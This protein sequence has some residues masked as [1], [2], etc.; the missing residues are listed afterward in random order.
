MPTWPSQN[1]HAVTDTLPVGDYNNLAYSLNLLTNAQGGFPASMNQ[2]AGTAIAGSNPGVTGQILIAAG[3]SNYTLNANKEI[4]QPLSF[5][6]GLLCAV[7]SLEA[8]T[9]D[10][11]HYLDS[12]NSS[13]TQLVIAMGAGV[14]GYTIYANWVAIGF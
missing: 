4:I 1:I 7:Y 5:P 3:R 11:T 8:S 2:V 13:K 6:N 10:G 12:G 14:A 9:Y